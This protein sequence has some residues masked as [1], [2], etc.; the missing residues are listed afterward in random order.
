MAF[1]IK[2]R[3]PNLPRV[4]LSAYELPEQ[5]L[6]FFDDYVLKGA[7]KEELVCTT[8]R[9]ANRNQSTGQH[10]PQQAIHNLHNK[11]ESGNVRSLRER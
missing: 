1:L 7:I 5:V 9:L 8:K 11:D 4:L 10:K 6:W 3:F 2:Q